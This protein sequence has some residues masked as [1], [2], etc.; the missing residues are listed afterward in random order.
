V[1]VNAESV[2]ITKLSLWL[3]TARTDKPLNNLDN[4]IKCGN[5]IIGPPES[6]VVASAFDT[7]PEEVKTNA[8]DWA[9]GFPE[10]FEAGGFDCVVGNP[11]YVRQEIISPLK[12]Y[13][14]RAY[15]C[16]H[17]TADLYA[18]FYE[19]GFR[20]LK[21]GGKLSYI[22]TNKWLRS[23]YGEPLR[24]FFASRTVFEQIVDFGH[25]P[26]FEDADTFPCIVVIRKPHPSVDAQDRNGKLEAGSPVMI[27]PVPREKLAEI[28]LTQYVEE[29][30]YPIPWAR[31]TEKT[32][33]LEPPAVDD[34]MIKIREIGIKLKN[35]VG[36]APVYGIKTGLNEA[37]LIDNE[38]KMELVRQTPE[39]SDII[40]PYVRGQDTAR[41]HPDWQNLWMIL[42]K[43]SGDY[44]WPWSDA[45]DSAER[46][47][48]ETYPSIRDHM[49]KLEDKLRNRQ[50]KGRYWWELRSCAYYEAF[51]NPKIIHT[52]IAWRPQFGFASDAIYVVNTAYVWPTSDFYVLAVVNSPLLW[53]YM[54]RNAMHGKD[55]AL[56]L[57]YSFTET[58][59]IAVPTDEIRS[60]VEPAVGQLIE[61]TKTDQLATRELLDWLR[62]EHGIDKPGQ[63]LE[64][65]HCLDSDRF[66]QEV[67]K[68]RPGTAGSFSPSALK[69][70]RS[71][72]EEYAA[73]AQHRRA[74]ALRL[75]RRISDLVNKAYGLTD[76]EI[77]LMWKT[78][79]PRMPIPPPPGKI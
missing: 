40:R 55:E 62:I 56:R 25:A 73:P 51:E 72:F 46:V 70:L 21:P 66:A 1:D 31:F 48:A 77:D 49:K 78:A 38:T 68:R 43:S 34:L 22:V 4:N 47:F 19:R 27:C 15:E 35:Y 52:D 65:F 76:E 32:W 12:P 75:E 13:L 16:Y 29:E 58:L 14:E 69:E 30:G 7:L 61:I 63:A 79:T 59:P 64:N 11:P 18:Y 10:V 8:F 39:A 26:I 17:G 37:F 60:E 20:L 42:L 24:R 57:I 5:S 50:D 54:W 74:E 71:V 23:G 44:R 41:W 45:G 3:K 67:K 28:S 53:S 33:S 2:E 6:A 9:K 36:V